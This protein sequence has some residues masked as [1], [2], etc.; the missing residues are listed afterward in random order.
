MRWTLDREHLHGPIGREIAW[1]IERIIR[2]PSKIRIR[3]QQ[4]GVT[5]ACLMSVLP[6]ISNCLAISWQRIRRI[7]I[8]LEEVRVVHRI[9]S[10]IIRL[11][12]RRH[13]GIIHWGIIPRPIVYVRWLM[14]VNTTCESIAI[15]I[16][17]VSIIRRTIVILAITTTKHIYIIIIVWRWMRTTVQIVPYITVLYRYS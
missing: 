8:T 12:C 6:L 5:T 2:L 7:R 4:I 13:I 10:R 1:L 15:L 3:I 14:I 17:V 11:T 16:P 9:Q